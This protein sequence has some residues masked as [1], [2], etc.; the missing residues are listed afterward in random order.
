MLHPVRLLWL[1]LPLLSGCTGV[2]VRVES[3]APPCEARAIVIVVDGAGS[4]QSA[5]RCF[6]SAVDELRLPLYVRSYDWTHGFGFGLADVV[7]RSYSRCQGQHLAEEIVQYQ[8]LHPGV[9]IYVV[10][11]SA[12]SAVALAATDSLP[13]D[14]LERVVLLAPAVST[15]YDLRRTLASARQGVDVFISERDRVWLGMGT[16]IVGTAA[17]P[18]TA[19]AGRVGFRT[20]AVLPGEE[21]LAAR[22][23]QHPW[24]TT[25]AA[26]GHDGGHAGAL[27]P[28]FLR[29]KVL[30]LLIPNEMRLD[31]RPTPT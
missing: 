20:P 10:A 21:A 3:H 25:A 17:G 2:P 29:A 6:A 4:T 24:T 28:V 19:A 14:T 22:L 9:P 8:K 12:G 27:A 16:A 30:P 11:Y 7:D 13:P 23:R 5:S 26:A 31:A 18:R 15:E 1:L